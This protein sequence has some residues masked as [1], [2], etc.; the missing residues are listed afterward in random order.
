MQQEMRKEERF[1]IE[2]SGK[3]GISKS[4]FTASGGKKDTIKPG[5]GS[6]R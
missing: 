1:M 5:W 6:C 2:K 4:I 3:N